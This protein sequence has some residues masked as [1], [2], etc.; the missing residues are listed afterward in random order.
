MAKQ[1]VIHGGSGVIGKSLARQLAAAGI[2][3]DSLDS[4]Q[5][6]LLDGP[7]VK[8]YY[9]EKTLSDRYSVLMA[10]AINRMRFS[11]E[12]SFQAN[13]KMVQ[14]LLDAIDCDRLETLVFLSTVDVYAPGQGR[15]DENSLLSPK[16]E[17]GAS[18]LACEEMLQERFVQNPDKLLILRLPG[19]FGFDLDEPSV[20]MSMARKVQNR[21]TC[22]LYNGGQAKRDFLFVDNLGLA[23]PKLL[24]D[25]AHGIVNVVTGESLSI[26]ECL[27]AVE[28]ALD[29]KADVRFEKID[30]SR[31]FDLEFN[32]D[33][34][35][36]SLGDLSLLS[37]EEAI[38]LALSKCLKSQS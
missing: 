19:V 15:I 5:C 1:I 16:N 27:R 10:A 7:G 23:L 9:D 36:S 4:R 6:D 30:D 11:G 26:L 28:K 38:Q 21:D 37:F 32:A 29:K 22:I 25:G 17:Y 24:D 13:V 33:R 18:K 3:L 20:V 14:N 35:L 12:E 34:L 2:R 8:R 31:S